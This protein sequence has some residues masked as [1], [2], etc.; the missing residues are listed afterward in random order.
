MPARILLVD[1]HQ[2]MREG[3]RLL[4]RD[5]ADL[6]LVGNAFDCEAGWRAVEELMPDLVIMDLDVPEEGGAAL[7]ARIR[8]AYPEIKVVVL[9]G[10]AE[11][12]Y[13]EA[14]L[15][16]GADGYVLKTGGCGDLVLALRTV[17]SGKNYLCAEVSTVVVQELHRQMDSRKNEA[18]AL[19][20]RELQVLKQIADGASTKEIA[21]TLGVSG[22]T[23]ETH[24]VNLMTKLNITSVAG[25]TKYALREGLT[26]L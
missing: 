24:R 5:Q 13:V 17:L 15:R 26:T 6:E 14:A 11:P 25:L 9:T 18:Q 4:L 8:A 22:K 2:I 10:H 23:I 20:A 7:T 3:L 21:F 12:H 16:A 19:T 1:D